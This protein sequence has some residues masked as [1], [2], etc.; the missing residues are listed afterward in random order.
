MVMLVPAG[1]GNKT[2]ESLELSIGLLSLVSHTDHCARKRKTH[3]YDA[4]YRE[5]TLR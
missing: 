2:P 4:L 1:I 3:G 5:H